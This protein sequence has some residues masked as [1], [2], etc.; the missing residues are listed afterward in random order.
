VEVASP[1]P[2]PLLRFGNVDIAGLCHF[3]CCDQIDDQ[4]IF[5]HRRHRHL[6]C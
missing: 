4:D 1:L 5:I 2:D 3:D 6:R